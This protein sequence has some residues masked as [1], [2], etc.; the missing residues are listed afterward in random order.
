MQ[1]HLSGSFFACDTVADHTSRFARQPPDSW[2]KH[3]WDLSYHYPPC[4][5]ELGSFTDVPGRTHGEDA[6]IAAGEKHPFQKP[7]TLIVEKVF[8][9][10]ILSLIHISEPTR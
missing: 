3:P 8:V 9:P 6:F 2:S 1:T 10:F 7:R 5:K 4:Q